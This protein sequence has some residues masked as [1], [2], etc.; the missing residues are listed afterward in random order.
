M[1][2]TI[3]ELKE[4]YQDFCKMEKLDTYQLIAFHNGKFKTLANVRWYIDKTQEDYPVYCTINLNSWLF[5]KTHGDWQ[6]AAGVGWCDGYGYDK[7][8]TAF[9]CAL[10]NAGIFSDDEIA[11]HSLGRVENCLNEL[12]IIAGFEHYTISRN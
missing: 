4:N 5:Q 1:K 2:L 6:S 8:S 11:G 12:A 7:E 9:E 10:N 3:K